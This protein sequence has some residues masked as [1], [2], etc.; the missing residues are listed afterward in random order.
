MAYNSYAREE[1]RLQQL[2]SCLT[3][4]GGSDFLLTGHDYSKQVYTYDK[5]VL[6]GL[7][8]GDHFHVRIDHKTRRMK[9]PLTGTLWERYGDERALSYFGTPFGNCELYRILQ[10]EQGLKAIGA[11]LCLDASVDYWYRPG[12]PSV[13]LNLPYSSDL[14]TIARLLRQYHQW[15]P[16]TQQVLGPNLD[17]MTV[18]GFD[19][20]SDRVT[21]FIRKHKHWEGDC[22]VALVPPAPGSHAKPGIVVSYESREVYRTNARRS[23]YAMLSTRVD[24]EVH[25]IIEF[26]RVEGTDDY[27]YTLAF[28]PA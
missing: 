6:R 13:C 23:E 8:V 16:D 5:E 18:V 11:T 26:K 19:W 20:Q 15:P 22:D 27:W 25:L 28:S 2:A 24:Q 1:H 14:E 12:W 4:L 7:T 10:I 9:S 17:G 21:R 3:P